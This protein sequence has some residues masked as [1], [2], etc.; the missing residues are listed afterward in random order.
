ME[1]LL[2]V[3][4]ANKLQALI[5]MARKIDRKKYRFFIRIISTLFSPLEPV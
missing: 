5:K 1:L 3:S 2:M 4:V